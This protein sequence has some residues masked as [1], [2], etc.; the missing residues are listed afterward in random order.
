MFLIKLCAVELVAT[1]LGALTTLHTDLKTLRLED[2]YTVGGIRIGDYE[3]HKSPS[4][5]HRDSAIEYCKLKG[6]SLMYVQP[7]FD[8]PRIFKEMEVTKA[9][10]NVAKANSRAE[11]TD[12]LDKK[13]Y[14]KTSSLCNKPPIC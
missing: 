4:A 2:A 3:F 14:L 10:I 5:T 6:Q 9:W 1:L 11:W 13:L 8:L 12:P 7:A